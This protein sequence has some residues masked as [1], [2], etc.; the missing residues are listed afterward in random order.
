MQEDQLSR[1]CTGGFM[2]PKR[3]PYESPYNKYRPAQFDELDPEASIA[4][5]YCTFCEG[6]PGREIGWARLDGL[7]VITSGRILIGGDLGS[8][9]RELNY[10]LQ[11]CYVDREPRMGDTPEERL[12]RIAKVK[13]SWYRVSGPPYSLLDSFSFEPIAGCSFKPYIRIEKGLSTVAR[14]RREVEM[15][16]FARMFS[17][18]A[19]FGLN[20]PEIHRLLGV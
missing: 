10:R 9:A 13:P 19:Q 14:A 17:R 15:L 12:Y 20:G 1:S 16:A 18:F 6:E 3:S 8:V 5:I 4:S 7:N 11:N 2:N